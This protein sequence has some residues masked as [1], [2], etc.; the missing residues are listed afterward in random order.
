[1]ADTEESLMKEISLIVENDMK[2]VDRYHIQ[3]FDHDGYQK[4]CSVLS[5]MRR[6]KFFTG[7]QYHRISQ[8]YKTYYQNGLRYKDIVANEP[9]RIAQQFIGRKDIRKLIFERDKVCL[10]CGSSEKLSLDHVI[11]VN[12]NG[13][14]TI[15]NLQTLCLSCNSRKSD[16]IIDYRIQ[17][18]QK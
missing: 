17:N 9:R 15:E 2:Y 14:N 10:C 18:I 11:P 16:K 12:K 5:K 6:L 13:P 8:I 7:D 3:Y 4:V 1:M